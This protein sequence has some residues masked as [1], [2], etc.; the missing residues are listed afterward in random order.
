MPRFLVRSRL[1]LSFCLAFIVGCSPAPNIAG[2]VPSNPGTQNSGPVEPASPP[3]ETTASYWATKKP[4]LDGRV[5][6]SEWSDANRVSVTMG[7]YTIV[8]ENPASHP[9]TLYVKNDQTHLYLAGVL[10][11]EELDGTMGLTIESLLMDNFTILFDNNNDGIVQP[12]EDKK[13]LY[14]IN[15]EPYVKDLRQ[16]SPEEQAQGIEEESEP[17]NLQGSIT[18]T[19]SNGGTF[20]F[21][22]AIPL[23]SGD[24]YDI[25]VKP[26][27]EIRWNVVY[28]DKFNIKMEGMEMGGISGVEGENALDWGTLVL[29][30]KGSK[31]PAASARAAAPAPPMPVTASAPLPPNNDKGDIKILAQIL[32]ESEKTD[33]SLK[34]VGSHSDFILLSF[35]EKAIVDKLRRENPNAIILLFNNPYFVFGDQF[36]TAPS[37]AE[38]DR[39]TAL[40]AL[41]AEDNQIINYGGPIYEGM[42][43]EQRLPMMDITNPKWQD[44]FTQQTRKHVDLNGFD[45]IFIDTLTED[46]PPFALGPGGK[47]PRGYSVKQWKDGNYQFLRKMKQAFAGSNKLIF[48]NGVTRSPGKGGALPNK[49]MLDIADGT[50]IEA[51]SIYKSMDAS[52]AT[53]KWY[54]EKTILGD[55][56]EASANGKWVVMEVYG[57]NDDDQIR[58]YALCSFLMVQNERT[59]FYFTRK[60]H[61][62]ALHWRPEWGVTLGKAKGTYKKIAQG[63]YQ[64]DFE[65]ARVLVNPTGQAMTVTVPAGYK[66]LH[67]QPVTQV[68]LPPYSGAILTKN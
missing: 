3:L 26:G 17:Q 14:I 12:G 25:N 40:Y 47:F 23:A 15:G 66:N 43:I 44:Y 24:K 1:V 35:H 39:R 54:F 28:F 16:L 57:D 9:F 63:G 20:N 11:R 37:Q 68:G 51:F 36:W 58:L 18:H 41:R 13:S 31:P 60:D 33:A 30:T 65:N 7:M 55:L 59:Y 56:Q 61:A 10:E 49:G 2:P 38:F 42:E 4:N 32:N 8:G 29:A 50:T 45:G 21:E 27:G 64:R 67:K 62:G 6:A 53:K 5:S 19:S 48:F 46:I 34:F 52:N 22:V